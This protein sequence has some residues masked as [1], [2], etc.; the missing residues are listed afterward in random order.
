MA[1]IPEVSPTPAWVSLPK[2]ARSA[3]EKC[4]DGKCFALRLYC[5]IGIEQP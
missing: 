4:F 3:G 2:D 5:G 1:S